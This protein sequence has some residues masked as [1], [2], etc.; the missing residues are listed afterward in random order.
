MISISFISRSA[1]KCYCSDCRYQLV[2]D[3]ENQNEL[4]RIKKDFQ[5]AHKDCRKVAKSDLR[6]HIEELNK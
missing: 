6:K 1:I 4:T 3:S 5:E 2:F